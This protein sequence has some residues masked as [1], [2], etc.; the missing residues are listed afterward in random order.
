MKRNNKALLHFS[1]SFITNMNSSEWMFYS[2]TYD[3]LFKR[4]FQKEILLYT[5]T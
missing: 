5:S 4:Y 3:L 1:I 2:H